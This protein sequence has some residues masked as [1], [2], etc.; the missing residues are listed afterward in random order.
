MTW[1]SF[2]KTALDDLIQALLKGGY[3]VV[4]P[5]V[6]E[7]AIVYEEIDSI[8]QLP[9]G[10][11]DHQ[12][13]GEYRLEAGEAHRYFDY[14]AGPTSWKRFVHPPRK[15]LLVIH[16]EGLEM[17]VP[18]PPGPMAFLGARACEL[19]ALAILERAVPSEQ[20]P[21]VVVVECARA[22][23]LCF[24]VS[25]QSG[26]QV[27][28][29]YDLVLNELE[30]VFLARAGT[31]RGQ[32]VLDQVE[33]RSALPEE[34]EQAQG[35]VEETA[36]SMGRHMETEGIREALLGNLEHPRWDD[37]A[38]RCLACSNC[39]M[40]CPTC[41]CTTVE[42][43]TDLLGQTA[44]RVQLWDSCFNLD[45]TYT[46]GQPARQSVRS[47]YRQWLTHKLASWYDQFD[48]SGC[49]GCG[50]CIAWCPV[51]IDLTEEVAAIREKEIP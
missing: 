9:K 7:G 37:V 5:R 23:N 1:R 30:S 21:F 10:I 11:R 40:V 25:M 47:R 39:T 12:A 29:A 42:D 19:A 33:T 16:Q 35:E 49:V 44:E 27:G 28:P 36:R 41:F 17:E 31:P 26:P 45:F 3:K 50:R 32:S 14:T 24:C 20:R 34:I 4:G 43:H 22:G 15:T 13:P 2:P 18:A 48:S 6:R 51:G 8:S 38:D 46:N